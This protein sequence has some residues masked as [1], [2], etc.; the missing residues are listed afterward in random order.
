MIDYRDSLLSEIHELQQMLKGLPAEAVIQRISFENRL[1]GARKALEQESLNPTPSR[2]MLTF[3][4][5]PVDGSRGVAADFG[6]KAAAAF[7]DAFAAVVA[8]LNDCLQFKGPIPERTKNQLLI[9]GTAVGSFG[10]EFEL[11]AVGLPSEANK[12]EDALQKMQA[13]LEASATGSDDD[14]GDLVDAIH[15]RA[16][17]KISEF[18]GL[19]SQ[20][21][22]WCGVEFKNKIF[23]FAGLEQ[24]TESV[25][26]LAEANIREVRE[27]Y[28]GQFVGV[29]P[30]SR[31]F[32]FQ[33]TDALIKGRVGLGV[34]DPDLINRSWLKR[35]VEITLDVVQV[36]QGRPRF[37]LNSLDLATT[38]IPAPPNQT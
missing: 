28:H 24:L 22:A 6:G 37:T 20:N 38:P 15:P 12:A 27:T 17:K 9:T 8:G 32:E 31:S 30:N 23:K 16:V 18:L 33:T 3:R 11:P 13:L 14:L 10:F 4:G 34:D 19:L 21:Q 25:G 1:K 26:R 2:V 35:D 5:R 36:G 29:L 7:T